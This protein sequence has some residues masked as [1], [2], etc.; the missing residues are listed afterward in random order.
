MKT[1]LLLLTTITLLPLAAQTSYAS[2]FPQIADG[3]T[4]SQS[5]QTTMTFVNFNPNVSAVV[6]V[7]LFSGT[8]Q[9][10]YIDFGAG[11][12][13][14]L[15]MLIPPMGTATFRS[16]GTNPQLTEGWAMINSNILISAEAMFEYSAYG[17]PQQGVTVPMTAP[18]NLFFSASTYL[19]GLAVVN[20]NTFSI[21]IAAVLFDNNGVVLD[22]VTATVGPGDHTALP[23]YQLFPVIAA[24]QL[25]NV[26]LP[27]IRRKVVSSTGWSLLKPKVRVH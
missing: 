3:G 19:S 11:P 25:N 10:L 1:K 20:P 9:S 21:E 7:N 8:G 26:S 2:Y 17:A 22:G 27:N 6:A 23:V 14:S 13:D 18:S 12:T 24:P 15:A 16:L 5:W 4:A